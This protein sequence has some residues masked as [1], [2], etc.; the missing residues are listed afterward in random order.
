MEAVEIGERIRGFICREIL[1]EDE[2]SAL[3]DDTPLLKGAMDSMGLMQLV[4]FLEEDFEIELDDEDIVI[5]NFGTVT[6][7]ERLI[8]EKVGQVQTQ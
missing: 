5:D 8:V 7:I 4:A 1:L 3:S 6:D 2:S